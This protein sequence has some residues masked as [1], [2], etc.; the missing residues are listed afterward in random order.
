VPA[1]ATRGIDIRA[2]VRV[3]ECERR[4]DE[5]SGM[6]VHVGARIGALAGPS[7]VL[8]SRTVGDLSAGS[9]LVFEDLGARQ[10]KGLPEHTNVVRVTER[11]DTRPA[12]GVH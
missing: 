12:A 5:W 10:L 4:G 9:G 11:T 3:G 1:L 7:E 2:G 6:A 8:T